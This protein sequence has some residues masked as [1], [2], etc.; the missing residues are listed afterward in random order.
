LR[1]G[2]HVAPKDLVANAISKDGRMCHSTANEVLIIGD[3]LLASSSAGRDD[4]P[5]NIR[6]HHDVIRITAAVVTG[7]EKLLPIARG[8]RRPGIEPR[9]ACVKFDR[10]SASRARV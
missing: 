6:E 8:A 7:V 4:V 2:C 3:I 1:I 5:L 9:V 10:V